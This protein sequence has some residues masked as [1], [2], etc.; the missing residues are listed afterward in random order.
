MPAWLKERSCYFLLQDVRMR[1]SNLSLPYD[2]VYT[3]TNTNYTNHNEK[4][5][6]KL[7]LLKHSFFVIKNHSY[8]NHL[9]TIFPIIT[10][11]LLNKTWQKHS[12]FWKYVYFRMYIDEE[13]VRKS[14][15]F[16]RWLHRTT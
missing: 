5:A 13:C 6:T 3:I 15:I 14:S 10:P 11:L 9:P 2:Y 1:K 8:A 7:F 12:T 16:K 4:Y